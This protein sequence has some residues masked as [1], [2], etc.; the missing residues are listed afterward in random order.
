MPRPIAKTGLAAFGAIEPA[1]RVDPSA[2]CCPI[3]V[4]LFIAGVSG[5]GIPQGIALAAAGER[6]EKSWDPN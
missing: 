6:E 1:S 2:Y 3:T 5:K 4:V